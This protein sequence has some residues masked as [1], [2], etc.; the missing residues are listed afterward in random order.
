MMRIRKRMIDS[1]PSFLT[2]S[3][4]LCKVQ[5]QW[6]MS[7]SIL[8][9]LV[10]NTLLVYPCLSQ[11]SNESERAYEQLAGRGEVYFR[12]PGQPIPTMQNL[13]RVISIDRLA[14]NKAVCA[15]ANSEGFA[16]FLKYNISYEVLT[17]PGIQ[18]DVKMLDQDHA[19]SKDDWDFYPT[20]EHYVDIMYAFQDDYP[21]ICKVFSIGQTVQGREILFARISDNAEWEPGEAQFLYTSSMHGDEI[22]GYVLLLRL[23]DYLLVN[24]GSDPQITNLIEN[25]DIWINPLANPDGTY[26]SGNHTVNGAKRFNANNVD[27]NRNY[28]DPE[29]GPHPDGKPWQPETLAFMNMAEENSFVLSANIHGGAEVFNYPWDTWAQLHAD[30]DWWIYTGREWADTAQFYSPPGY[31]SGFN[32]GITNGYAWYSI[33]G[34][35]QDYMNYFHNCREFTLEISDVKL[36]SA[37]QLPDFWEYNYRSFLNYMEQALFGIRGIVIDKATGEPVESVVVIE[38]HDTDNSWVRSNPL[39]GW[40]FRPIHLGTYKLSFFAPGYESYT[41]E[42]I[43]II[44]RESVEIVAELVYSGAGLQ[45][46]TIFSDFIVSQNLQNGDYLIHYHGLD[47]VPCTISLTSLGGRKISDHHF[48]FGANSRISDVKM[49]QLQKGIYLLTISGGGS[50]YTWKLLKN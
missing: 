23:I 4:Y 32:N 42:D 46:N 40:F 48:L 47:E 45:K 5:L 14:D 34:G 22:T 11:Q 39:D 16:G 18:P 29:H 44:N 1:L 36:P 28:P 10:L 24:Y 15:Y 8:Y 25:L 35:R 19:K 17:P 6:H 30:D 20:Y 50:D 49:S 2:N 13:E 38:G 12:F 43:K 31:M 9:V 3:S 26:Y 37:A 21:G 33:S 27:L 7:R 41:T